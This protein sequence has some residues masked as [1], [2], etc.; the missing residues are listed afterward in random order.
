MERP[1]RSLTVGV[2]DFVYAKT[3]VIT[4]LHEQSKQTYHID[5]PPDSIER[6]TILVKH[7]RHKIRHSLGL[8]SQTFQVLA[9]GRLIKDDNSSLASWRVQSGSKVLVR[10]ELEATKRH[11]GKHV[12]SK[13]KKGPHNSAAAIIRDIDALVSE[14]RESLLADVDFFLASPPESE[15]ERNDTQNRLG[16]LLLQK[17]LKLDAIELPSIDPPERMIAKQ[18]RRE[19][20]KWIQALIDKVECN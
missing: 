2:V 16:E 3:L 11:V 13:A 6:G 8:G 15:K 5:F 4:V 1:N 18:K 19:G 7:L 12:G 17:L 9:A 10:T 20:V 14:T